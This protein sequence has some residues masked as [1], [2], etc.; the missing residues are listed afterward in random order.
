M[1]RIKRS[2]LSDTPS[3][4]FSNLDELELSTHMSLVSKARGCRRPEP[5][6]ALIEWQI[7]YDQHPDSGAS[8]QGD[9]VLGKLPQYVGQPYGQS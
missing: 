1:H 7:Q 6:A 9:R 2:T 5:E 4:K 8:I 3:A